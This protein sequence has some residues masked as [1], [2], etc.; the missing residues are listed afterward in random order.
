MTVRR[1]FVRYGP[2]LLVFAVL[3]AAWWLF[4]A[5]VNPLLFPSPPRVIE[6]YGR[7]IENGELQ[8]AIWVTSS[9]Y[10]ISVSMAIVVGVVGG[11]VVANAPKVAIAVDPYVDIVYATPV[12]AIVPLV[13][14]WLG[15]G[16]AGRIVITF[17]GAVIPIYINAVS[18]FRDIRHDL[19]EVATSFGA[20]RSV[21]VR[22]VVLPGAVPHIVTGLRVGLGRALGAV[23]VAEFFLALTGLGGIIRKGVALLRMD[24][25]VAAAAL[26]SIGGVVLMMVMTRIES[27]LSPWR[28]ADA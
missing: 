10:A 28:A 21:L 14:V 16:D 2:A 11:F 7:L 6:A 22:E 25:M 24:E 26:L 20:S 5:S 4:A 19:I 27:R 23:I 17:I 8:S 15:V 9:T 18:G 12:V 1:V 13:I 3:L